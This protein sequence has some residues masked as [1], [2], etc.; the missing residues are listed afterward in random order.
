MMCLCVLWHVQRAFSLVLQVSSSLSQVQ[1]IL[2]HLKEGLGE[3]GLAGS[4][5]KLHR[6]R[7]HPKHRHRSLEALL[8]QF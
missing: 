5:S 8:T 7:L 3:M 1:G 6:I 2:D 4:V